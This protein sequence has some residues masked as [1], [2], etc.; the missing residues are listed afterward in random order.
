VDLSTSSKNP[1]LR[2]RSVAASFSQSPE[3][4]PCRDT[5]PEQTGEAPT[6]TGEAYWM[7]GEIEIEINIPVG[8]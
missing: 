6:N 4:E 7:Q 8:L 1:E 5:S 2:T 3:R